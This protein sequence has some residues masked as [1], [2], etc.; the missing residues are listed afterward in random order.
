MGVILGIVVIGLVIYFIND[1]NSY[2]SPNNWEQRSSD[3]KY[4]KDRENKKK[5]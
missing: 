5:R 3:R 2:H 1:Y 4:W